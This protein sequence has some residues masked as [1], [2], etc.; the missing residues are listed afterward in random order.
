MKIGITINVDHGLWGSGINQNAMYLAGVLE[1]S[2]NSVDLIHGKKEDFDYEK[3][4]NFNYVYITDSFMVKYDV[5]IKLGLAIEQKW[6]DLWKIHN[7]K[8]KL[9]N[10]E[11]GN[12]LFIDTETILFKKEKY[13]PS[14]RKIKKATPDQIWSIPQME[15]MCIDYYRYRNE[16][17]NATVVPFC[18]EPIA[19][20]WY[21]K[22][23]GIKTYTKRKLNRIGV[24]EPNLSLMKNSIYP[25]IIIDR[26]FKDYNIT[27]EI[28]MVKLF[29][30][31]SLV[32]SGDFLHNVKNT[33][34]FKQG[35]LK[36]EGRRSILATLYLYSDIIVSWQMN[37]PLNYLYL[38]I[39][40][41]G[42]PIIHNGELCKDIG[43]YYEKFNATQAAKMIK[44][45]IDNH[46]NDADYQERNRNIIK[47][48]T[49]KN[50]EM[51]ENY[52]TL[53]ED[54]VN[55]RFIKREYNSKYNIIK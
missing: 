14:A 46:N 13:D 50:K 35:K 27:D 48:Y 8:L 25:T 41:Y 42:W 6:F 33:E 5:V 36:T 2:G 45:A 18:W 49:N 21:S 7:K 19:L 55:D 3:I 31:D 28:K 20:D 43:Y 40:W 37:N 53:L 39:A 16:C 29:G 24:C 26:F 22:K 30:A 32:K 10:Y 34:M 9:V 44:Y 4:G 11:C 1:K 15:E 54:L 52:K 51:V 23:T 12:S 17:D 38:D 47:R